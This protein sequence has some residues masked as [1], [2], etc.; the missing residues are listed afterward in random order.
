MT[1]PGL[2]LASLTAL[3]FA[4]SANIA[5]AQEQNPN[6]G[7]IDQVQLGDVWSNIDVYVPEHTPDVVATSTAS[8][9]LAAAVRNTGD[10]DSEITQQFDADS[11][12][13]SSLG[14]YSAGTAIQTTTAYGNAASSGTSYGYNSYYAQQSAS[15]N[16]TAYSRTELEQAN[17]I[18]SATTAMAN[19]S[20]TE[21]NFGESI[22]DQTQYSSANV[23]AETDADMCCDG[24]SATFATTAG[25]NATSATG[26]TN[27]SYNRALQKTEA[28]SSVT[29]VTD[30]YMGYGTN[31]TAATNSFGNSATVHNEWGYA[32]L[33]LSGAETKQENN[34]DVDAQTYVTLDHWDG[35]AN[36]SAYGVGNSAL[37]SNVGSD[38]AMYA[39]QNNTGTVTS[40]ASFTGE[41]WTGGAGIMSSTA[42]GNAATATV[43]NYCSDA[44]VGGRINQ[45]NSGSVYAQGSTS[46]TYGGSVYGSASAVGNSATI[47]SFGD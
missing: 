35:Y 31:V 19:V 7:T 28:G 34:A 30:V 38:T 42:I 13:T 20:S 8:G 46:T 37:L 27:T 1:R 40:Q 26:Y 41:S 36:A 6:S 4:M 15:G 44:A 5:Q 32:A 22:S 17:Q 23:Y 29:G 10:V 14:G 33:G 21:N 16:V 25:A 2:K 24:T 9:N 12:A 43:C 47:Q 39:D 3:T 11:V 45:T 18:A